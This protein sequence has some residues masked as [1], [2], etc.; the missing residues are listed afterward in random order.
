M[1]GE[2]D[3]WERQYFVPGGGDPLLFYVVYGDVDSSV[4]LSRE[5]YRSEG[6]PEGIDVMSYNADSDLD[7]ITSFR[8]GYVWDKFVAKNPEL[9]AQVEGCQSCII[10]RGTPTESRTL[11]YLRDTIGLISF[12]LDNGGCAVFDP[13]ILRWWHPIEWK[14]RIFNPAA[15]VP[16]HHVAILSSQEEGNATEKWFHT[17]GMRKFGRPD[18]SVHNI[19]PPMEQMVINLCDTLITQ[20]A[21]GSVILEGERLNISP[22]SPEFLVAHHGDLDNLEFNNFYIELI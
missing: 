5:K 18:I 9:A 16:T 4:A 17:R 7:V 22:S 21:Y 14:D 13:Q 6:I 10:I 20:E 2:L 15:P 19:S 1:L 12:M 11:N 8:E 3:T